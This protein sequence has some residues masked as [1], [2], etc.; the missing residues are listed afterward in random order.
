MA[1]GRSM[2]DGCTQVVQLFI[3]NTVQG[4]IF[5]LTPQLVQSV[6]SI[7]S[8]ACALLTL[9]KAFL[10]DAIRTA[11]EP[12]L[13]AAFTL[14]KVQLLP[15]YNTNCYVL[16]AHFVRSVARILVPA[17]FNTV[18]DVGATTEGLGD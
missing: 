18:A 3:S 4:G 16:P 17:A 6:P 2:C 10:D 14:Q 1:K 12:P 8:V 11:N 9:K 13:Q 7:F 15:G 5:T